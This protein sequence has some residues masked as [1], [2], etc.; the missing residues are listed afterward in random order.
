MKVLRRVSGAILLLLPAILVL[1]GC[2]NGP[3]STDRTALRAA[4]VRVDDPRFLNGDQWYLAMIG[5]E[6]AWQIAADEEVRRGGLAPSPVAVIDTAV[7]TGHEDL[8]NALTRDGYNFITRQAI[9]VPAPSQP[10]EEQ[11]GTHV[12]GLVGAE[13]ENGIG[14]TGVGFNSSRTRATPVMPVAILQVVGFTPGGSPR[15][16]GSLADLAE[17]LLYVAGIGNSTGMVPAIPVRVINLSLGVAE[18]NSP[19]REILQEIIR[20]L[21]ARDIVIVAAAGNDGRSSLHYPARYPEVIA[22]GSI[23]EDQRRSSFSNYGSDLDLVAPG[24]FGPDAGGGFLGLI[25]TFPGD[26][27]GPLPGTSM[28][29]PLVAGVAALIRAVNPGLSAAE[30]RAILSETATDLGDPGRDDQ[31]GYGLVN[32]EAA[33]A[34]AIRGSSGADSVLR[35]RV[36]DSDPSRSV[37]SASRAPAPWDPEGSRDIA[38]LLA[39]DVLDRTGVED[40]VR[41]IREATGLDVRGEGPLLRGTLSPG[42]DGDEV[43]RRLYELEFILSAVQDRVLSWG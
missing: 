20:R 13:R 4:Q 17:A 37:L 30:V 2:D 5:A 3:F 7:H 10:E 29:A 27:Y 16:E 31:F 23:N 41:R 12:A 40:A 8:V 26:Q 32:A 15:F 43:L 6:E 22:V 25:S 38:I 36:F 28:A 9:A 42:L 39:G 33:V 11:H 34:R 18:L 21:A 19:D 24:A 14:I 35:G 1:S